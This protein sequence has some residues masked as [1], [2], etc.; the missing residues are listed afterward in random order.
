MSFPCLVS[1]YDHLT[2]DNSVFSDAKSLSP[3]YK[4]LKSF[5]HESRAVREIVFTFTKNVILFIHQ[6]LLRVKE[7]HCGKTGSWRHSQP[8]THGSHLSS[9]QPLSLGGGFPS[10]QWIAQA[11]GRA[12]SAS[13]LKK[14]ASFI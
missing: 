3:L 6:K 1:L 2:Q 5:P 8:R 12:A 14:V 7:L 11:L 13:A 4:A 10:P 9:E